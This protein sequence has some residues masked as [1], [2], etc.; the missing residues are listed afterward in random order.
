MVRSSGPAARELTLFRMTRETMFVE[1]ED[2][3]LSSGH[4][5]RTGHWCG[6][7]WRRTV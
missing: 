2:T 7:Q 4:S 3:E 6:G 5:L 1:K